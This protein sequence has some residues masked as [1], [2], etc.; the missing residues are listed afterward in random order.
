MRFI[1]AVHLKSVFKD[2]LRTFCN[3]NFSVS[4]SYIGFRVMSF[5]FLNKTEKHNLL[6]Q[7][8]GQICRS[9]GFSDPELK[10][11]VE[12]IS[13]DDFDDLKNS[14]SSVKKTHNLLQ[15]AYHQM[16]VECCQIKP[17]NY[18]GYGLFYEG[19]KTLARS[20]LVALIGY[21][22]KIPEKDE[23]AFSNLSVMAPR[24]GSKLSRV[25]VGP[26]RFVNHSCRPN[27]DYRAVEI[28]GR[29]GVQ[30]I[31]RQEILPGTELLSFYGTDFFGPGN[32]EC[33][34]PHDDLHVDVSTPVVCARR[35]SAD[36]SP[37][38]T[39]T[40]VKGNQKIFRLKNFKRQYQQRNLQTVPKKARWIDLRLPSGEITES[41]DT[42]EEEGEASTPAAENTEESTAPVGSSAVACIQ[43]VECGSQVECKSS[44]ESES[45]DEQCFS[46]YQPISNTSKV[47][48]ENFIHCV[49]SIVTKHGTSDKEAG[50]WLRLI[51]LSHP[52]SSI[53][54]FK[55][56]KK[57][58]V[59]VARQRVVKS[60]A[61]KGG[62]WCV[63][64]FL[65]EI[66]TLLK[67][68]I[69]SIVNYS[70]QRIDGRDLILPDFFDES[71]R[72]LNL[73]LII[74]T[75]G[76]KVI[77]CRNNSLWPV[78]IA[79]AN[80]PPIIR[81]AFK[82]IILAGLWFGTEKPHWTSFLKV[83]FFLLAFFVVFSPDFYVYHFIGNQ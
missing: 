59:L 65:E 76:V 21:L 49:E 57:R 45:E 5:T 40:P 2:V 64:N 18:H 50:E 48:V 19:E 34:C 22:E 7:V 8:D 60:E 24:E 61:S 35:T 67:L 6:C 55:T 13:E 20:H 27:C 10:T 14:N 25:M 54:S 72:T 78:W 11:F 41:D 81:S 37:I 74:N 70:N 63:L 79:I 16:K 38:S 3:S 83:I 31:T 42:S 77:Q 56:L 52:N 23:I 28:N 58:N 9:F 29:K 12:L 36:V 66:E 47:S 26:A 46:N 32:R 82:N 73:F 69:H 15:K 30:I 39:D 43:I 53:P 1:Y 33:K 17:D 62:E 71:S 68:N 75:D 80:L 44:G 51:R 4:S